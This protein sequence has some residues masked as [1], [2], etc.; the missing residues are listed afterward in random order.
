MAR[1]GDVSLDKAIYLLTDEL[2]TAKG[3]EIAAIVHKMK[4][5]AAARKILDE[6]GDRRRHS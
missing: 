4:M 6:I 2:L 3:E 5:L 1:I